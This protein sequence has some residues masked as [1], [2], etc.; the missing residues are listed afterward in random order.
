[1][2]FHN[3]KIQIGRNYQI[4]QIRYNYK[5]GH[6]G[7]LKAIIAT[8]NGLIISSV[9]LTSKPK[10][11]DRKNIKLIKP[12]KINKSR[13]SYFITRIRTYPASSYSE[14]YTENGLSKKDMLVSDTIYEL[15]LER[16][17][18]GTGRSGRNTDL[19]Q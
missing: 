8:K 6:Y 18:I 5:H 15:Y 11:E 16:K 9:F 1:M 12:F 14:K 19:N 4:G 3:I 13:Q 17:K 10:S 2:C 7:H